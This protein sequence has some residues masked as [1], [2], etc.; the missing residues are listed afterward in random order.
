[1]WGSKGCSGFKVEQEVWRGGG[2]PAC[3]L[4]SFPSFCPANL[5]KIIRFSSGYLF[6]KLSR[7][8]RDLKGDFYCTDRG[9][10]Q[11]SAVIQRRS[12]HHIDEQHK[13]TASPE[14][15]R[16]MGQL[17]LDHTS[18]KINK[19]KCSPKDLL[20]FGVLWR[21]VACIHLLPDCINLRPL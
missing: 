11:C 16:Q 4:L 8:M 14:L 21:A 6:L 9:R 7:L 15:G 13:S 2:R 20:L 3:I 12:I 18:K 19:K 17:W 1:M 5:N 10:S